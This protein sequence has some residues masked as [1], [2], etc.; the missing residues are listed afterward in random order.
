MSRILGAKGNSR[1]FLSPYATQSACVLSNAAARKTGAFF[2]LQ[3]SLVHK[4]NPRWVTQW[5]V[6]DV[7]LTSVPKLK[8]KQTNLT[9]FFCYLSLKSRMYRLHTRFWNKGNWRRPYRVLSAGSSLLPSQTKLWGLVQTTFPGK[10]QK[11]QRRHWW[12]SQLSGCCRRLS[13]WTAFTCGFTEKM[14]STSTVIPGRAPE[15][16]PSPGFLKQALHFRCFCT[17]GE[18]ISTFAPTPRV[19]Q[20]AERFYLL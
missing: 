15:G 6:P 13:C 5:H 16:M 19:K 4:Q 20:R 12:L 9:I 10:C 1:Q 14:K 2:S 8:N 7:P 17:T 3:H 18:N 11:Q